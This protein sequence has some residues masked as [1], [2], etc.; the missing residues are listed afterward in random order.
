MSYILPTG[1]LRTCSLRQM[2]DPRESLDW[3]FGSINFPYEE[4]FKGYYSDQTH[5]KCQYK[6]GNMIKDGY[7][8]LC[9]TGAKREGWN[10]EMM[11]AHY[12]GLH[13]GI[14]LEFD[15]DILVGSLKNSYPDMGF[16]LENI[17]YSNRKN[18]S[19]L[20]WQEDKNRDENYKYIIKCLVKDMTLLKSDCWEKEDER[21]LV[22]M[23]VNKSLYIPIENALKT[24][25]LG[26]S[27][28]RNK[29]FVNSIYTTLKN[30]FNLS[31]LIYQN[32]SFERW[33]IK[34]LSNGEIG[35]CAFEDLNT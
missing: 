4:V 28:N 20:H 31:L 17:E 22:C 35:T 9:F 12:G 34:R 1:L 15:E 6:Y 25:Y 26:V 27:S 7:Q 13:S 30:R 19:F 21:R 2:N 16:L 14:C 10:N 29:E 23:G 32:N 18:S 33:G 24:V 8:V 5:I 3:S 11:W